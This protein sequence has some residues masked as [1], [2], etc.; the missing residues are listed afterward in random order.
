MLFLPFLFANRTDAVVLSSLFSCAASTYN[1]VRHRKNI[2]FKTVLPAL[3]AALITIPVAVLFANRVSANL[4]D[5]LLGSVLILLSIYFLFFN[6]RFSIKPTV[7][8]S[9]VA[10]S[11]GGTLTGLF[12]TGG[13]PIVLFLTNA[14]SD[15][16]VY[17]AATQFYFSVTSLY[18]TSTRAINGDITWELLLYALIG[19]IGCLLGNLLGK[20]VFEKLNAKRLKQVIYVAMIISGI[21]MIL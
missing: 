8:N 19:M 14:V 17:F 16:K 6:Q 2:P 5:I 1:A 11:L 12:S 20:A 3:I 4:F 21:L 7:L 18:A 10:G 9:A 13:P 15:P